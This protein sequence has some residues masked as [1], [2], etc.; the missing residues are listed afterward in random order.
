MNICHK[1]HDLPD[2]DAK[3]EDVDSNCARPLMRDMRGRMRFGGGDGRVGRVYH[4]V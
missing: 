4:L 2:D 1:F 3:D